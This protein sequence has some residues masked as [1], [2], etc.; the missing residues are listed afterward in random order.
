MANRCAILGGTDHK[1]GDKWTAA[2]R[3][4]TFDIIAD[5]VDAGNA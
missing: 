2:D 3:N 1:T 5:I 4:D